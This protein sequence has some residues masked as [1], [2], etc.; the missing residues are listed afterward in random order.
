MLVPVCLLQAV[1][2][3]KVTYRPPPGASGVGAGTAGGNQ[4][5]L[6]L[7]LPRTQQGNNPCQQMF[8]ILKAFFLFF[9]ELFYLIRKK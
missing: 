6:L 4:L 8:S 2:K 7:C 5:A 9:I 3:V 1:V